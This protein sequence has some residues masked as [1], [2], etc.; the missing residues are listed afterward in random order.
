MK[1]KSMK[2]PAVAQQGLVITGVPYDEGYAETLDPK[3]GQDISDILPGSVELYP[4]TVTTTTDVTH[5][6]DMGRLGK[7]E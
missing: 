6:G 4:V 5:E 3:T 1:I 2:A 7:S